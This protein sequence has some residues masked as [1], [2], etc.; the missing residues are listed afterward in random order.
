M[1]LRTLFRSAG[2]EA[3]VKSRRVDKVSDGTFDRDVGQGAG[4]TM[5]Y[6]TPELRSLGSLASLTLGQNGS[7]PDGGGLNSTQLGGMS[8]CGVSGMASGMGV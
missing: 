3:L 2:L 1:G 6:K 5:Q 4:G 7:C 8:T